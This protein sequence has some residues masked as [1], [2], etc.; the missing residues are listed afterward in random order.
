MFRSGQVKF[1][2]WSC[3]VRSSQ[4]GSDHSKIRSCQVRTSQ[5]RL[6]QDRKKSG[7][8]WSGQVR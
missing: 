5:V 4:A 3:L 2:S 6:S 8:V 7:Q 1:K